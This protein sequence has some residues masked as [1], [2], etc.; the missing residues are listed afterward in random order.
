MDAQVAVDFVERQLGVTFRDRRLA[1]EALT[2]PSY[3]L[4][5]P[6]EA[7][8]D[9]QRLEW[10]GDAILLGALSAW[11][12]RRHSFHKEGELTRL[13]NPLV[14]NEVL[15]SIGVELRLHT[16]VL[17]SP[18]LRTK[19]GKHEVRL[20]IAACV[21]EAIIGALFCDQGM[22]ACTELVE[23]VFE[24][25]FQA[26]LNQK[27]DYITQAAMFFQKRD[28]ANPEIRILQEDPGAPLSERVKAG[29]YVKGVQVAVGCG[30]T[31]K[32]AKQAAAKEAWDGRFNC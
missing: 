22:A 9:Y 19:M 3:F 1:I 12:Y 15:G 16:C 18:E 10:L 21:F 14:A 5:V 4:N 29:Y 32:A 23:R 7:R 8:L 26:I 27:F 2:H 28:S 6:S 25:R 30:P 24:P 11:L 13:R 17:T 20:R 31:G